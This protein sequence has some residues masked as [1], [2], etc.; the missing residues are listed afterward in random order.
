MPLREEGLHGIKPHVG[1]HGHGIK[2]HLTQKGPGIHTTCVADITAFGIGN[3]KV[4]RVL[5]VQVVDRALQTLPATQAIRLIEGGIWLVGNTK[6]MGGINDGFIEREKQGSPPSV[7]RPANDPYP[8]PGRC[9]GRFFLGGSVLR[10]LPW[11]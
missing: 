3:G 8:D 5:F 4:A 9:T 1:S 2:P 11:S 6:V 7:R 10:A